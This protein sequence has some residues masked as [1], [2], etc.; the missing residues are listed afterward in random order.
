MEDFFQDYGLYSPYLL[1]EDYSLGNEHF[2][3]PL[4][5]N[6]QTFDFYCENEKRFKTFELQFT[7]DHLNILQREEHYNDYIDDWCMIDGKLNYTFLCAC[8]CLSCNNYSIY[9]SL[10]VYSNNPVARRINNIN[11]TFFSDDELRQTPEN[12]NIYIQKVGVF[13]ESKVKVDKDISKHFDRETNMWYFKALDSINKN[14]GIGAFAYFRRIIE[15]ELLTIVKEIKDLPGSDSLNINNLLL[16]Y[17]ERNAIY[18][19]YENIWDYL[20]SSLKGLGE[21]PIQLLYNQTSEGLHSL[22]EAECLR[23]ANSIATLLEFT[24]KKINEENSE[25]L[26]VRKAIRQLKGN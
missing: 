16:Q 9:L 23:R 18:S 2:T 25:I 10:N 1:V 5:F 21:N 14:Y 3:S 24:L 8:K 6:G 13:P 26:D 15:K 12:T 7:S 17:E 20:P 4:E 19:I 22:D 11:N